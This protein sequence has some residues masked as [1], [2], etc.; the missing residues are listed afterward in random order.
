MSVEKTPEF[1]TSLSEIKTPLGLWFHVNLIELGPLWKFIASLK[2]VGGTLVNIQP[3][4][5]GPHIVEIYIKISLSKLL[6]LS[7]FVN[8]CQPGPLKLG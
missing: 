7:Y 8:L 3:A 4:L 5:S 2:D 6:F 1:C